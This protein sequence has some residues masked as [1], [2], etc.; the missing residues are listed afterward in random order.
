MPTSS[1]AG[2]K[3]YALLMKA[4]GAKPE[5]SSSTGQACKMVLSAGGAHAAAGP[6]S[7]PKVALYFSRR[8]RDTK[9]KCE[10][11][12]EVCASDL[13]DSFAAILALSKFGIAMAAMIR[14]I[15]TTISNS[16]K[17]GRAY[18]FTPLILKYRIP[19]SASLSEGE[20]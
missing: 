2:V 16:I 3:I 4:G 10:W 8:K 20:I 18:V 17:I 5:S 7:G 6:P 15:A 12:S 1:V 11:S 14:M 13:E 9:F 19:L